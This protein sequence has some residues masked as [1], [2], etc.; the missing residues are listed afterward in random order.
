MLAYV[1]Q[2]FYKLRYDNLVVGPSFG[3]DTHPSIFNTFI[4]PSLLLLFCL[5]IWP[6]THPSISNIIYSIQPP[7][8]CCF[9]SF[10][11]FF[12]R[13]PHFFALGRMKFLTFCTKEQQQHHTYLHKV[14]N[15][16]NQLIT[17]I[18][19]NIHKELIIL[20]SSTLSTLINHQVFQVHKII[21]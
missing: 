14:T 19:L 7:F 10:F 12:F 5:L 18:I 15:A 6:S 2:Y 20:T 9:V 3:P 21:H 17:L 4:W 8:Y 1:S 16:H 13:P 11:H